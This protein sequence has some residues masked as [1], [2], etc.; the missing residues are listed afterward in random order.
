[1]KSDT[2]LV[3]IALKGDRQAYTVLFHR[4]ERSV[5]AVALAV[6]GDYH[7]AQDV[8]QEAFATA[9]SKLDTLRSRSSFG[10]WVRTIAR[11]KAVSLGR[12]AS[13]LSTVSLSTM[14]EQASNDGQ[15]NKEQQRLL[16]TVM[17]LPKHEH[18]VLTLRYFEG[19]SVK[20]IS[21]ITGRPVGTVT[22]QL[23]R[24]RARLHQWLKEIDY[25]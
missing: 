10:A 19:H 3:S 6:A 2:E 12:D 15:P 25:E 21:E 24:A 13:R 7:L 18:V 17:R 16:E 22:M 8:V 20:A 11:H 14:S 5:L 9:Y 1:M 4:H 23:S